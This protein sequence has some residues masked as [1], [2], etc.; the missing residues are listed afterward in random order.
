MKNSIKNFLL[1]KNI[2]IS[3]FTY[4]N[5][6]IIIENTDNKYVLKPKKRND[7]KEIYD[8]LLSRNFSFFLYPEN[9][10][11][12]DYEL[13][14]FIPEV[15]TL[16][17]EK[18]ASLINIISELHIRTT[19]YK[20]YSLDE[21]KEIYEE[22]NNR[23]SYLFQYYDELEE[24]FSKEIYPAPF[25]LLFLNNVSKIYNTLNYSRVLVEK[26]YK[27]VINDKRRRIVFLHNHLSLDHFIDS[28]DPKIIN[29]DYSKYDSPIYDFV[30]FYKS[31]FYE[32][33]M[34][35]L[36]NKYQQRYKFT[37]NELLLFFIEIII[38]DKVVFSNNVFINTMRVYDLINYID[39]TR[40][41]ILEKEKR[42]QEKDYD[43]FNKQ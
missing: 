9:D 26:W 20:E 7:K 41:F 30:N 29:F 10:F 21:I 35:M 39:I 11:E 27:N 12:D 36:F 13:Y 32:L 24:V 19:T 8:Y 37:N 5:T 33:D 3:K 38:P 6:A 31:H 16:I 28:N 4:K 2:D 15:K 42:E 18:A 34:T 22:K 14:Q 23:I 40:E 43:K 1:D 25:Q 17:E